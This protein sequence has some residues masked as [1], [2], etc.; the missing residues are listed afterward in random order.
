MALFAAN[1]PSCGAPLSLDDSKEFGY[2]TYCGSEVLQEIKRVKVSIDSTQ[3]CKNCLKLASQAFAVENYLEAY[4][5]YAKVLEYD[6][7]SYVSI[8]QK[9]ICAGYLSD[10]TSIRIA[11]IVL[12]YEQA[13]STARD[14]IG[15]G[16]DAR[17]KLGT[18]MRNLTDELMQ[19]VSTYVDHFRVRNKQE[20]YERRA[21]IDEYFLCILNMLEMLKAIN[22]AFDD[23][24]E[25]QKT[26]MIMYI[27]D[28]CDTAK[29]RF[30]SCM[31]YDGN[32]TSVFGMLVPSYSIYCAD[33][34]IVNWIQ[35][36]R[37]DAASGYMNLASHRT[38]IS[39]F[40]AEIV[41]NASA[42]EAYTNNL[43]SFWQSNPNLLAE[44]RTIKVL[45]V[46]LTIFV[47]LISF[48][49]G[50]FLPPLLLL[51]PACIILRGTI[52]S[53][54][55]RKYEDKHFPPDLASQK[56]GSTES[57]KKI[58]EINKEKEA[59]MKSIKK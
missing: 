25:E 48:I 8:L 57:A 36:A 46:M 9:G 43:A 44:Y 33:N 35:I 54:I 26:K 58:I 21:D 15:N 4:N 2:C 13:V 29:G 27:I 40:Q 28:L 53:R 39:S 14:T 12:G 6:G 30:K 45:S 1:C 5:Y 51:I 38:R 32:Q 7:N 50:M 3:R 34:Q 31:Y 59:F 17:I 22:D 18:E 49:A 55:Q 37:E 11:E 41:K 47:C 19:F 16:T 56:T 20:K 52:T 24:Y 42:I 10:P 23:A